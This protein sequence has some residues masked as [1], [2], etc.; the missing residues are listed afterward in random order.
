MENKNR[1][2]WGILMVIILFFLTLVIFALYTV[3]MFK[4]EFDTAENGSSFNKASIG[5]VEVQGVIMTSKKIVELLH[6]AEKA[7]KIKAIIVRVNS[8]G[9]AVGPSQEIYEEMFRI[10]K[11]VKPVYV[12]LGSIAASGGYYIA[13]AGK[14]IFANRGTLTGSI[15]VIMEFV[16][17]SKLYQFAMISPVIVKAGKY[18]DA[19][20]PSRQLTVEEKTMMDKMLAGVHK[21]FIDDIVKGRGKRIKGDI[22]QLAQGQIFSGEEALSYGLVDHVVGLW[23]A[24][25]MISKELGEKENLELHFLKK[26]KKSGVWKLLDSLDEVATSFN[27]ILSK[28]QSPTLLYK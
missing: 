5:V 25:R 15:G 20:S 16:N 18:K 14:K 23:E 1:T 22:Q 4:A 6:K 2:L 11:D 26:K 7:K 12:S 13:S 27:E 17:L 8:P 28:N 3:K 19:G 24:G 9:G 21:Q 10:N